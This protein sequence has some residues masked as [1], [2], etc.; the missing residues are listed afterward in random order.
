MKEHG[1]D[2]WYIESCKLIKYMFPKAHAAAYVMMAFRI[3]WYKINYPLAYYAAYFS[4]RAKAF[5]YKLMCL[6][7]EALLANM[8]DY[9]E[10]KDALTNVEELAYGDMKVVQ[11]MYAR[12]FTF[13]PIDIYKAKAVRFQIIDG[14]LMPPFVSV[15]GLGENAAIALEEAAGKMEFVSKD[16]MREAAKLTKTNIDTMSELGILDGMPESRQLSIFD[17]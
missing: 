3:A 5:D 13:L 17:F 11:E 10:R 7:K 14:K 6:G 12:G 8:K 15:N 16:E 2:D 1:V 4:I 9:E